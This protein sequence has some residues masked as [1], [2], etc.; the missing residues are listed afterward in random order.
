MAQAGG[1]ET[2]QAVG[3]GRVEAAV[4]VDQATGRLGQQGT[5]GVDGEV[6]VA[7]QEAGHGLL[8]FLGFERAGG[9]DEHPARFEQA[10]GDGEQL[11]LVLPVGGQILGLAVPADVRVAAGW[12]SRGGTSTKR[13]TLGE[14]WRPEASE[15]GVSQIFLNPVLD[16]EVE[17]LGV[18]VHE[19]VHAVTPGA[20]HKGAFIDVAKKVGLKRPWTSTTA[21]ESLETWLCKIADTLGDYPHSKLTPQVERKVQTTRMR[22]LTADCCGYTVR[23]TQKWIEEGLPSCPCGNQMEVE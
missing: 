12:P 17:I 1:E 15:D 6:G 16:D 9:V 3:R 14:C 4:R 19:L 23:T 21:D 7:L 11:Q 20:G 22:K 5:G 18:L 13:R 8:V 10:G 2:V